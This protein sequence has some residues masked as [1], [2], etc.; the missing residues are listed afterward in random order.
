MQ[1][2]DKLKSKASSS[3]GGLSVT[4]NVPRSS[5][6]KAPFINPFFLL[7]NQEGVQAVW[8][9]GVA[10]PSRVFLEAGRAILVLALLS[11]IPN[12]RTRM[13]TALRPGVRGLQVWEAQTA[14]ALLQSWRKTGAYG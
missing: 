1:G 12:S 8:G 9:G 13:N 14:V 6:Q 5:R 4:G 7:G 11:S 2:V 10:R 3:S